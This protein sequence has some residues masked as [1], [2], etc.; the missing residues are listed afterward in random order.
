MLHIISEIKRNPVLLNRI[1][2]HIIVFGLILLMSL[3]C[4]QQDDIDQIEDNKA[5]VVFPLFVENDTQVLLKSSANKENDIRCVDLLVFDESKKFVQRI[6]VNNIDGN[7]AQK[8]FS[9]RLSLSDKPVTIHVVANG[10]DADNLDLINFSSISSGQDEASVISSLHTK[11]LTLDVT[12]DFPFLMTG[13]I[14]LNNIQRSTQVNPIQLIRTVA[15]MYVTCDTDLVNTRDFV[16]S[17]FTLLKSADRARLI[18]TYSTSL[19]TPTQV[20]LPANLNHIDYAKALNQGLWAKSN[21]GS[22][23]AELYLYERTNELNTKG[24][25]VIIAASYKGVLGYY[26]VWLKGDDSKVINIIRNHRYQIKI[27]RV[28]G[29]G[30]PDF[31][32]AVSSDYSANISTAI[33]DSDTDIT[34]IVV[35]SKHKLGVSSNAVTI[36]GNGVKEIVSVLYTNPTSDVK[37]SSQEDWITDIKLM[38][39]GTRKKVTA[40]LKALTINR[41]GKITIRVANLER[42]IEVTQQNTSS[43]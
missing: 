19:G 35:D 28:F 3:A 4:T 24:L 21:T 32:T 31:N 16:L 22:S 40:N 2:K 27:S 13:K 26:K 20:S 7:E 37:L 39:E 5:L 34:D 43:L 23:T 15:S 14:Q 29:M 11:L 30:Y 42:V 17:G 10:R 38:G 8:S 18:P 9:V 6:K 41:K 1:M 33:S 25:S 12:V 36:K